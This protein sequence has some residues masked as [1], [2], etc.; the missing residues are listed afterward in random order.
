M[1]HCNY[2]DVLYLWLLFG[3]F[4]ALLGVVFAVVRRDFLIV[5]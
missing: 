1:S 3:A 5:S 4:L 2:I